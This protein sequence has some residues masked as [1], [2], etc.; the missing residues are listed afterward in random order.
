[1]ELSIIDTNVLHL[2]HLLLKE[3]TMFIK[4]IIKKIIPALIKTSFVSKHL[5]SVVYK[6]G[7]YLQELP[8][9]WPKSF[10]VL[11]PVVPT[12]HKKTIGKQNFFSTE[13]LQG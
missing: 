3:N 2:K 12:K 9:S 13:L 6:M 1:M 4:Q 10:S 7:H 5:Y 11:P 8:I